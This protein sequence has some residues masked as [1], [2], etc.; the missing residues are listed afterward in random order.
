MR[1]KY[2]YTFLYNWDSAGENGF[3]GWVRKIVK[4]D[5]GSPYH[6]IVD[7]KIEEI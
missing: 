6:Y 3:V 5:D 1:I 7:I 2:S 4:H